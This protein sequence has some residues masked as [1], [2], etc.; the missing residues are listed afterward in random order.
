MA[1]LLDYDVALGSY[2]E[3]PAPPAPAGDYKFIF[4]IH[5]FTDPFTGWWVFTPSDNA[6]TRGFQLR[7]D[8]MRM[9]SGGYGGIFY[10][11]TAWGDNETRVIE[12]TIRNGSLEI[13]YVEV[14]GAAGTLSYPSSINFAS[15]YFTS[16]TRRGGAT[17]NNVN[18]LKIEYVDLTTS[19]NNRTWDA[20]ASDHSAG[21]QPV[22][23]DTVGGNNA[24]GVN[25]ATDGSAYIDLGGS[26]TEQTIVV[27][28][29]EQLT[30]SQLV[31]ILGIGAIN[32]IVSE[33]KSQSQLA[34]V[35]EINQL[36][37]I[38]SEQKTQSTLIDVSEI[39]S[40]SAIV[41][42]QLTQSVLVVVTA[43][44]AQSVNVIITEQKTQSELVSI[45]EIASVNAIVTEQLTQSNL[46]NIDES[47]GALISVVIAE[48]KTQSELVSISAIANINP[49]I[50]EQLTQT[51]IQQISVDI[52]IDA[53]ICE[54]LTQSQLITIV[55]SNIADALNIDIDQ[56]TIEM[57]T[58]KYTIEMLTPKY[59]IEH[60][61]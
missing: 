4:T 37:A 51:N 9:Y 55:Q 5:R 36:N 17:P 2:V 29:T 13:D 25:F 23:T 47:S 52:T 28:T 24:T 53:I 60:I 56:I 7:D 15:D 42:E 6:S 50:C 54:Q 18:F 14:D 34:S 10:F 16:G 38:T 49:V 40:I 26:G 1:W 22:L 41:C 11:N 21:S 46:V 33:Q 8:M 35:T 39:Y 59:T 45:D 58:P 43:N 48:Q 61:H 31:N 44:G 57:L 12:A 3:H 30:Q 19:A 32:A 20:T 27:S